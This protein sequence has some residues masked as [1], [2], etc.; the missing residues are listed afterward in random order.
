VF[1]SFA[2]KVEVPRAASGGSAL[3]TPGAMF[4]KCAQKELETDLGR[5]QH[6]EGEIK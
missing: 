4:P 2:T 3:F 1:A 6:L 5:Y